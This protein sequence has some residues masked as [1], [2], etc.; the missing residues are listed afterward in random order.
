MA[1]K[2]EPFEEIMI[3]KLKSGVL[4][5]K[6]YQY[7]TS[8]P[9]TKSS[10]WHQVKIEDGLIKETITTS[11][12]FFNGKE[13]ERFSEVTEKVY[14]TARQILGIIKRDAFRYK[15]DLDLSGFDAQKVEKVAQKAAIQAEKFKPISQQI[16]KNVF[17]APS[18]L[19][20]SG[21]T[22]KFKLGVLVAAAGLGLAAY[23]IEKSRKKR[24]D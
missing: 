15:N 20:E 23:L 24:A 18:P 12:K 1:K 9:Y 13:N 8:S 3:N 11:G 7:V 22:N 4:D 21:S 2:L 6:N 14:T 16:K 19:I 10:H 5:G 17:H